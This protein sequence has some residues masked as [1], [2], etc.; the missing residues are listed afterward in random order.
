MCDCLSKD[1]KLQ[2]YAFRRLELMHYDLRT[3]FKKKSLEQMIR[4]EMRK[5]KEQVS[6]NESS[7]GISLK[8]C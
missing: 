1:F 3:R 2:D 8:E 7:C 4:K 6:L 5:E